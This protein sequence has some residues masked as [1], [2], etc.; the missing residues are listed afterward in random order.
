MTQ[1]TNGET[2]EVTEEM[3]DAAL[4]IYKWCKK[5]DEVTEH[6]KLWAP[7][8]QKFV[9]VCNAFKHKV[10]FVHGEENG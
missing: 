3:C 10:Q 9:E 7:L 4:R 6:L 1:L 8:Y 2:M 5:C